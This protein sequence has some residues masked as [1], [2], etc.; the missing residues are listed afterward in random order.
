LLLSFSDYLT[1]A[2]HLGFNAA[3]PILGSGVETAILP[4]VTLP[5]DVYTPVVAAFPDGRHFML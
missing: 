1:A 3:S 5:P 2:T 4:E